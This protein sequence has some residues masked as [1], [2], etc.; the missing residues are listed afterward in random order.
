MP[1]ADRPP[2]GLL[3]SITLV[4]ILANTMIT[5][6]IPDIL[7]DLGRGAGSAGPL[8]SAGALPGVVLAPVIGI[9]A[10]RFGRR[11]ILLPCLV[12]FGA[13]ALAATVA[14]TFWTLVAARLLQGVGGAGLINL[15]IVLIGDNWSGADRTR[16]IG[17][18]SAVLTAALAVLPTAAGLIAEVGNWR[19]SIALGLVAF[20]VAAVAWRRLPD[21]RPSTGRTLSR[22]LQ[23]AATLV[24]QPVMVFVFLA[25][26][27]LFLVIFGVFLTALPVHLEDRFGLGPGARGLVLSAFAIGATIV[28][29][30]LGPIRSVVPLRPL[31]VASSFF[32]ALASLGL[33]LAPSL[34]LVVVAVLLYGFGDGS[35]I[36][37]LQDVATSIP[38]D[39]QRASVM[40]VWV[41]AVRGGQTAG[42]LGAAALF[43]ATSTETAMLVGAG[44]FAAVGVLFLVGPIDDRV[45]SA[46]MD[47]RTDAGSD[48]TGERP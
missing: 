1:T 45:L 15:A 46:G 40:A 25:G 36:P 8:V 12:A 39:E 32:I 34:I 11:P 37:A 18:N 17:R 5:A 21:H 7:D 20:P 33:A 41:S 22:Q 4:G 19:W 35:I 31:L 28:S 47:A 44:L 38:P 43:A 13:G 24:R 30:N 10:D 29:F 6:N 9:L 14:P 26:F 3:Y 27:V 23:D 2:V 48:R 42:P 16:L